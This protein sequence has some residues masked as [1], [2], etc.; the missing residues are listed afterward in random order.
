MTASPPHHLCRTTLETFESL[1]RWLEQRADASQKSGALLVGIGGPG[2]CGKSTM[3]RWLLGRLPCA[4]ELPL[5][6]FRLPR[7]ARRERGL[8][9]SHPEANNL[10]DLQSCLQSA[11]AGKCFLRPVFSLNDGEKIERAS[12]PPCRILLCDGEI[13]V[14]QGLR[15]RFDTLVLV[16]AHWRIQLNTRLTRDLRQRNCTLEKAIEIFLTS[17]LRDYPKFAASAQG[18]ANWVIYR[19]SRNQFKLRKRPQA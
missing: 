2:G 8:F 13:A 17:N 1:A 4:G 5:D 12:V 11:V 9:G 14:H 15:E 16:D 7:S 19:N 18:A 3:V 10:K 6:D